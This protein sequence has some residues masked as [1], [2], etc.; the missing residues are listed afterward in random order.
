VDFTLSE[1]QTMLQDSVRRYAE[2]D[3]ELETRRALI[4]KGGFDAKRW[5]AIAEMGWLAAGLSEQ[6]GGFGGGLLDE[7]VLLEEVGRGLV[8]EPLRDCG[9]LPARLL[10]AHED[11]LAPLLAGEVVYAIAHGEEAARGRASWVEARAERSAGN[12]RLGGRKTRVLGGAAAQRFLVSARLAGDADATEGL[13]LFLVER[14]SAGLNVRD[15]RLVD[16]TPA[17]DLE[18]DA[19]E[20]PPSALLDAEAGAAIA[21]L[22]QDAAVGACAE[23]VGAM[24]QA[25]WIARDYLRTRKQFGVVIGSFQA[26]QHRMADCH[27]ALEQAR[28]MLYRALSFV[29]GDAS[30]RA[31]AISAAK[32]QVGRSAQ[33]VAAQTVQLH[34]GIG[35]TDEYII[36]H[37]FKRLLVLEAS[38]GNSAFHLG[39]VARSLREAA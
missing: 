26:L 37:Y 16:G 9:L 38:Y 12:Y 33:F 1:E 3:C 4:A 35:V 21:G 15:Y 2:R 7:A 23:T 27:M 22:M 5:S 32:A 18:F 36:G 25:I 34:G 10:A 14:G 17:C 11:L 24:E 13:G 30:A 39:E 8:P 20:L 19:L 29:D 6:H 28:S 31:V